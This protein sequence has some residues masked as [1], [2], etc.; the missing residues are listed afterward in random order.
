MTRCSVDFAQIDFGVDNQSAEVVEGVG[1]NCSVVDSV[2]QTKV[3]LVVA[4]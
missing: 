1:R 3:A 2:E 4:A